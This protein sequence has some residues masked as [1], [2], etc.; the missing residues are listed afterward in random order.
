MM[1]KLLMVSLLGLFA[2][3]AQAQTPGPFTATQ[4][5]AGRDAYLASCAPCHGKTLQGGGEAPAL[6]G[7]AFIGSWGKRD[8][9]SLYTVIKASMPMGHPDSLGAESYAAITAFLLQANGAKAGD[10][11]LTPTIAVPIGSIATGKMPA[12]VAQSIAA[13]K[14]AAAPAKKAAEKSGITV[15]GTV[16]HYTPVTS[17]MLTHPAD[18]D[19][20]MHLRTY[21]GWSYSPL[22]QVTTANAE[23]LQL[24]W[25]WAMTDGGRQQMNPLV[26]DGVMFVSNNLDNRVQALDA[27]TGTLIWENRIGPTLD[28]VQ[29]ANRTMAL[30]QNLL[31]YPGTD[32]KLTALD[33]RT[34]KI[35]WQQQISTAGNK[36][37]GLMVVHDKVLLGLTRCDDRP[38]TEYCYIGALDAATG[39]PLWKFR[40]V[41]LKGQPGGNSWGGQPDAMRAGG[42]VWIAG[43]YDPVLNTTYWGTGQAKPHLRSARGTKDG[44]TD[45]TNSTVALDPDTGKLKWWRNHAPGESLDLDEVYERTLVDHNGRKELITVGKTGV[46]WKLDRATG[47]YLDHAETVFQNVYTRIDPKTG[48][49]TYRADIVGQKSGDQIASC[50]S[51]EGGHDW[52]STSFDP[53]NDLVLIPL[54]QTCFLF[55]GASQM[56][57]ESPG[58]DGNMGRL[59]AYRA[60]DFKPAWSFQ[61]RSPFLTGVLSTAGGVSFV[62]DYDRVFRAIDTKTGETLWQTRLGTTVQGYPVSFSV[63]GEQFIAV[64]TGTQGGSPEGKPQLMLKGEVN[65]P[66]NGQ[67]V[68]VFALPHKH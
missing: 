25:V 59:S 19:W 7:D 67:A 18:A 31:I 55:G 30:W 43:T 41:A 17:E 34:G 5:G 49:P 8:T 40:T 66:A 28:N 46:M 12:D 11:A 24:K 2:G 13:A 4:A 27:K 61:Q 16:A 53:R 52:P 20:L 3:V 21:D 57:Y 14:P 37:G 50:P 65:R 62:G 1:R 36:I 64:T 48:M 35:L 51:A 68:Y 9:K 38:N 54:S 26:H 22:T 44:A 10:T 29:N 58:S 63:D 6:T 47:K 15:A 42:D 60:A 23:N 56:L 33:A 39:K 45:Y 32:A